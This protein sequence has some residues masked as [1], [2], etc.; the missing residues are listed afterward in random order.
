MLWHAGRHDEAV[1]KWKESLRKTKN[2]WA[3]YCLGVS[4]AKTQPDQTSRHFARA[5]ALRPDLTLLAVEWMSLLLK[6]GK[7]SKVLKVVETLP[8][9]MRKFGRIRILTGW[10]LLGANKLNALEKLLQEDI[11]IPDVREGE[12]LTSDLWFG[13]QAKRLAK[14]RGVE[15]TDALKLEAA[16][17]HPVPKR[18]DFRM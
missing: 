4:K 16:T 10:A 5:F 2:P 9:P 8:E 18:L 7:F 6:D 3:E 13:L 17:L 14:S 11:I 15:V 12:S 1:A